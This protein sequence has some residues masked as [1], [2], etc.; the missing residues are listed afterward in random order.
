MPGVHHLGVNTLSDTRLGV[1]KISLTF[2]IRTIERPQYR[3]R[4]AAHYPTPAL[5]IPPCVRA[6]TRAYPAPTLHLS[7]A[8]VWLCQRRA[9]D[10]FP[11]VAIQRNQP[12]QARAV[13]SR[14]LHTCP[15]RPASSR[16]G[17]PDFSF[18][19]G[20]YP[21]FHRV[22]KIDRMT[23]LRIKR[24]AYT[25]VGAWRPSRRASAGARAGATLDAS[26]LCT[27]REMRKPALRQHFR[28]Q[29]PPKRPD[30]L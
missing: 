16:G 22:L 21:A 12:N 19:W 14:I 11:H 30:S 3:N 24:Q 27:E 26:I 28:P 15:A 6:R 17:L 13:T 20:P 1:H 7:S 29:K 23:F 9:R 4:L 5:A 2:S 18:S 25:R 10:L 8:C